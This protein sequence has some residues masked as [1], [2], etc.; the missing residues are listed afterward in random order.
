MD[1]ARQTRQHIDQLNMKGPRRSFAW[2]WDMFGSRTSFRPFRKGSYQG[3][4]FRASKSQSRSSLELDSIACHERFLLAL[5]VIVNSSGGAFI[6][7]THPRLDLHGKIC[8]LWA[9][10]SSIQP[11]RSIWPPRASNCAFLRRRAGTRRNV[12]NAS[13]DICILVGIRSHW[14]PDTADRHQ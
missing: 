8:N 10:R 3:A 5:G 6:A 1:L 7:T 4:P 9:R 14:R 13:I 12:S 11:L 2:R